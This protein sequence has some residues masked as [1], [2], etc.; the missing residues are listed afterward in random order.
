MWVTGPVNAFSR[1]YTWVTAVTM[2][3]NISHVHFRFEELSRQINRD[4]IKLRSEYSES[5]ASV[6]ESLDS[7]NR[8]INAKIKLVKDELAKEIN[9]VRKMIVLV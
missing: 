5:F 7:T 4:A 1:I 2:P 6:K 8:L 3:K 9:G